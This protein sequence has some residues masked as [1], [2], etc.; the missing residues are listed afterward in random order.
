MTK[1]ITSH[2][3]CKQCSLS[4][5]LRIAAYVMITLETIVRPPDQNI[6]SNNH[7]IKYGGRY[8]ATAVR[9]MRKQQRQRILS[10]L[11]GT[12]TKL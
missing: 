5:V 10:L 3:H 12:E 2:N 7:E 6:G 4:P 1:K 11:Q 9:K 8:L